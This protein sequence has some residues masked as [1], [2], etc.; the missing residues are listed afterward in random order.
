MRDTDGAIQFARSAVGLGAPK[1]GNDNQKGCVYKAASNPSAKIR[2]RFLLENKKATVPAVEE[3][4]IRVVIR[5]DRWGCHKSTDNWKDFLPN[6]T[7]PHV[8]PG[9][10]MLPT[11]P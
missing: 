7:E 5:V 8:R 3:I 6:A 10:G 9:Y 1:K 4:Q 11:M 2:P